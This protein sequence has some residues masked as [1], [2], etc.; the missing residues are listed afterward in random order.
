MA[1]C[2]NRSLTHSPDCPC[3][4]N[5]QGLPSHLR[6]AL[7]DCDFGIDNVKAAIWLDGAKNP[8]NARKLVDY[9]RGVTFQES[10]PLSM[11]V[12]PVNTDAKLPDV[13]TKWAVRP[14]DP[15]T[16]EPTQAQVTKWLDEWRAIAL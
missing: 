9:L 15:L 12:F 3:R 13:F 2:G 4:A 8:N 10:M 5:F 11:F 6:P 14:T 7:T 1:W 16:A